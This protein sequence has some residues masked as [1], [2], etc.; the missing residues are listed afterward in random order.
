MT[1]LNN[2]PP[3]YNS[4]AF[5]IVQIITIANL[6]EQHVTATILMEM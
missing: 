3:E 4:L 2:L 1:L 6:D 5:T